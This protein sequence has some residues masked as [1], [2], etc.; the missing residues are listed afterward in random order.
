MKKIL[1]RVIS[2]ALFIIAFTSVSVASPWFSHR[3]QAPIDLLR[4]DEG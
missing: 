1:I 3:P 2:G 4:K